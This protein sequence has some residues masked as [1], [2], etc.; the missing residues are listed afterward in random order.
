L[1]I[2]TEKL[3]GTSG[4]CGYLPI[5][6][7]KLNWWQ[8]L[9]LT[10]GYLDWKI[11]SKYEFVVGSRRVVKS[12][13]GNEAENKA[14]FYEEDLWTKISKEFFEGKLRKGETVYF[15]IV[16]YTPSGELI[17][18]SVSNKKLEK[19]LDKKEYKEFIDRYGDTTTF[20]Y[21]CAQDV[22]K[23]EDGI[24]STIIN[25]QYKVFVYRITTTNEDGDSI[26]YSWEQVKNRCEQLGVN[27]TPELLK[28][29]F[30]QQTNDINLIDKFVQELTNQDS[31]EFPSHIREGVCIRI[32]N[33]GMTPIILKNK[34]LNFKILEG[35]VKD[36]DVVDIEES[37]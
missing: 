5:T 20:T 10:L 26:D 22:V 16:G 33:G 24:K 31:K 11:P 8:K 13:G 3:H 6:Q 35:I 2:I 23:Y 12:I 14:H 17:M 4:R 9:C 32:E 21:G 28:T 34:S 36:T 1:V 15:E 29:L 18:P 19:F 7:P 25:I 30:G 27:Y 37:N